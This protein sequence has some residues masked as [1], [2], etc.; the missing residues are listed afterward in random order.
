MCPQTLDSESIL[1]ASMASPCF[2]N[3]DSAY[4]NGDGNVADHDSIPAPGS[5]EPSTDWQE[6]VRHGGSL[7]HVDLETG[8]NGWASPPGRLF[9][10]RGSK[11]FSKKHKSASGDSL[12]KPL[13]VDWLRSH[14]K[15]EHALARRDNRVMQALLRAHA[16]GQSSK[17]FIFAV[18]LQIPGRDFHHAIFYFVTDEP[19]LHGSLLHRFIHEEDDAFRNSRFKL[20]N[21]IVKGPW[22]VRATVGNY[23]ACLL[24][25]ALTCNYY[26]GSNYFEI[27]VDI[28]SSALA[29]AI[30]HLALGYINSVTVDMAFL[31]EAQAEEELPERILGAV[32]IAQ[33]EMSSARVVEEPLDDSPRMPVRESS[34]KKF[35]RSISLLGQGSKSFKDKDKEARVCE[36]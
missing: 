10:V 30:L 9:Q 11:Y 27:D 14:C 20:V 4:A 8:V 28:S 15:L 7:R 6:E 21:R 31:I 25:K 34:W 23:A 22:I 3:H 26:K 12:F 36:T 16:R 32:R 35:S 5:D 29:N 17:S 2:G 1:G 24:G 18:N 33:I 13:G 19:I